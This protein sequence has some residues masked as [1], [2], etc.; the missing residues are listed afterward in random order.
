MAVAT[1]VPGAVVAGVNINLPTGYPTID[2]VV[3]A[4]MTRIRAGLGVPNHAALAHAGAAV[5]A[6]AGAAVDAH[7]GA[8]V[9]AHVFTQPNDH[10]VHLHDLLLE[11][12]ADDV[13]NRVNTA[14][15]PPVTFGRPAAGATITSVQATRGVQNN[16]AAQAHAG[17]AVADHAI[18]AH[19]ALTE[20]SPV[21]AAV[22][23]RVDADTITLDVNTTLGDLLT[24]TYEVL[25][26]RVRP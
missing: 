14:L 9:A 21:V 17:A 12:V 16:A 1:W 26:A 13:A 23:T 15:G 7:A 4:T 2:R 8:A 19:G 5:D 22:A 25:G 20:A 10:A 11:I 24:L 6:H 3:A 18:V